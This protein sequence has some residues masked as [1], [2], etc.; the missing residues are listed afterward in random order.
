MSDSLTELSSA[1]VLRP[2]AGKASAVDI[3]IKRA[4]LAVNR[5]V[6]PAPAPLAD[7][8]SRLRVDAF[9][10]TTN[11]VTYGVFGDMLRYWA[12]FPAS[13]EPEVWGRIPTWGYAECVESRSADLTVGERIYGFMPMSNE[14]VMTP[15]RATDRGLFDVAEHRHG[16]AG[17]Y[18]S[19][20][21]CA[22]DPVYRENREAHQM[23]LYPLFFTSF[24]VDDFMI[25]NDDF[26]AEQVIIS[27]ASAKTSIGAALF[28]NRRGMKVIGLTSASNMEFVESL[29]VYDQIL[30]YEDVASIEQI[31]S[32]YVDIAGNQ[33]VLFAVHTHLAGVL[34]HSMVVG[35]TNWN[36]ETSA[37]TDDLPAPAPEF[38]F[39]PTQISKRT[40]QWGR[41]EL[42]AKMGEAWTTYADWADTWI[43]FEQFTG[44]EEVLDAW[45]KVRSGSLNPAAGY[46][47]SMNTH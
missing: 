45:E 42:E 14:F 4:D 40:K 31:P 21:R 47:C 33:D 23:L 3:E 18:N 24:I 34:K 36:T 19:Y 1:A 13:S 12:V 25:D 38:L 8:Q 32:V 9:A 39:A 17:T 41:E 29:G 16:L 35:N 27:S 15:G 6:E 43:T 26:G 46:I 10:L 30:T 22:T 7:G 2:A 28:C 20:Q 5:I 11:N 44:A 37:N